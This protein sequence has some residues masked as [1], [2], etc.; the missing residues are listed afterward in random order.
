MRV[1]TSRQEIQMISLK[2]KN[3]GKSIGFVPTMGYLHEG[4]LTLA[5]NARE[6][7]DIVIMS[8]FVNPLQFGPNEDFETYPR[9]L[10]QDEQLANNV[11]I[12]YLFVPSVEEIYPNSPAIQMTVQNRVNVLCG[13]KREGHFD[14]V[15]TV[16]T[17]LFHLVMPN[18][19]YFGL[20]DAQQ[21]SVVDSLIE[22][23]FFPIE[24]VAV[25]TVREEDGL[26]K[27]SRNVYL[28]DQERMEAVELQKSLQVAKVSIQ[29]GERN[30]DKIISLIENHLQSTTSGAIDYIEM[31]QYPSLKPLI[32]IKGKIII[33]LAVQFSK[34]RLID[35]I[36]MEIA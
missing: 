6:N 21:V 20:K 5:K 18:R 26:A 19:V 29:N 28:N 2:H 27:S 36:I 23:F 8:I 7:N 11:G 34:A 17:K 9:D 14:G 1:I 25:D 10:K 16:L 33:G 4:H 12:D 31:Y 13:K 15:V 3:E 24:L 22:D 32:E 30:M 35:N